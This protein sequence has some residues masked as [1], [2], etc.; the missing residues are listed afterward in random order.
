MQLVIGSVPCFVALEACQK[1]KKSDLAGLLSRFLDFRLA[2]TCTCPEKKFV[3]YPDGDGPRHSR[4]PSVQ[5]IDMNLS[6]SR[7]GGRTTEP[8][9]PWGTDRRALPQEKRKGI[10]GYP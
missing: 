8:S 4:P 5:V 1:K 2:Q 9:G 3:K 10:F 6:Q 7:Y